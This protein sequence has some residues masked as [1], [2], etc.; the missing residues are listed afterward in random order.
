MRMKELIILP[1]FGIMMLGFAMELSEIAED[2]S[3]QTLQ[4]ASDMSNAI[5]CATRGISIYSCSPNLAHTSF[6]DE[7]NRTLEVF[8]GMETQASN[9]RQRIIEEQQQVAGID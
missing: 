3:D 1:F 8:S 6:E 4:F 9:I 2:T 7:T 5:P